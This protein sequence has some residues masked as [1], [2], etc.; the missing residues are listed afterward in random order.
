M[1]DAVSLF[2]KLNIAIVQTIV[3]RQLWTELT[4]S[5]IFK[6]DIEWYIANEKIY[7]KLI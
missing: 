2:N 3:L 6:R 7:F 4:A 5:F 1:L